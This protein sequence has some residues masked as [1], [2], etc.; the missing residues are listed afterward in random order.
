MKYIE[1]EM[2]E[3]NLLTSLF[4]IVSQILTYWVE[5]RSI[6]FELGPKTNSVYIVCNIVDFT[7]R[8]RFFYTSSPT[9][10]RS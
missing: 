1:N 10:P 2:F 9:E 7:S 3:Y 4:V 6:D 8:L 5:I